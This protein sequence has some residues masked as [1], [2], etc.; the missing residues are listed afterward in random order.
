[1]SE[2]DSSMVWDWR[3]PDIHEINRALHYIGWHREK[4]I[5][6]AEEQYAKQY[7]AHSGH[8]GRDYELPCFARDEPSYLGSALIATR[9]LWQLQ[10]NCQRLNG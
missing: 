5:E 6:Y 2:L 9:A 3:V 1:M 7:T 4:G 8:T 10:N